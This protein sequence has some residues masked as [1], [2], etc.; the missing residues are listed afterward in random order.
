[1]LNTFP[2][3]LT[4]SFF[5]PTLLRAAAACIFLYG[6]TY[7]WK[8]RAHIA[9][10]RFPII[11]HASWLAGV[12]AVAHVGLGAMLGAGY[13]TQV[14]ALL[15]ALAAIKAL[16]LQHRYPHVMPLSR[17]TYFLLLAILL[18]LLLSGAGALAFDLRL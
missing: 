1:M 14:A 9:Q 15:G 16:F 11:G 6:A 13:Y 2:D 5:A 3:L 12:V 17:G 4:Y 10:T 8:H 7:I 18:S